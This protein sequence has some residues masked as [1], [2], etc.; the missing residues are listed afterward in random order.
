MTLKVYNVLGEEVAT[1]IDGEHEAGTFSTNWDAS[2]MPSGVYFCRLRAGD[3]VTTR[4]MLLM[5]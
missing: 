1:L 4:S 2:H 5:R 3:Y